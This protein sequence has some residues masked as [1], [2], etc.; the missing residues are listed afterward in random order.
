M[1]EQRRHRRGIRAL[2]RRAPLAAVALA[3]VT[4]GILTGCATPTIES[5]DR[6]ADVTA[7]RDRVAEQ[8]HERSVERFA[9]FVRAKWGP[10]SLPETAVTRWVE[11]AEW[12]GLVS[13]CLAEKGFPGARAADDGE[14]IDFS[15]VDVST[16]REL[17]DVDVATYVC[18]ARFPVRSWFTDSVRAIELPWAYDYITSTLPACLARHGYAVSPA[19]TADGFAA[20][21]RSPEQFDPYALVGPDPRERVIAEA[22]CP[23]PEAL[24][25]GIGS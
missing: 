11:Y 20:G 7:Q 13:E 16:A 6:L 18:Q 22:R 15:G 2:L 8:A 23:S 3:S 21:W 5:N 4:A 19:P 1:L 25:D 10:V 17:F 14:R 12:G 9:G 24:L